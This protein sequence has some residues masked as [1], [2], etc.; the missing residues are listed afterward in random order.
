MNVAEGLARLG[1]GVLHGVF[2][3]GECIHG[4]VQA[5]LVTDLAEPRLLGR[6]MA[7][8]A[9]SW[10]LGFALGEALSHLHHLEAE[11]RAARV[12]GEDGVHRFVR[13]GGA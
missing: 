3:I 8:S 11:G 2:G 9:L 7:L 10:Q 6:Y 1:Y 5:P 13:S 4:A 12:I